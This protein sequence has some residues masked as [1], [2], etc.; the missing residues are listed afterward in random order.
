MTVRGRVEED[1]ASNLV[2]ASLLED[3]V[4]HISELDENE[5]D[6][7][8]VDDSILRQVTLKQ[9]HQQSSSMRSIAP[10]FCIQW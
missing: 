5:L 6:S 9:Q 4:L 8:Q 2:L 3:F 7:S 10:K 1:G